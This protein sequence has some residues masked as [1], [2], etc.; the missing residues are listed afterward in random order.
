MADWSARPEQL[1]INLILIPVHANAPP[2]GEREEVMIIDIAEPPETGIV[3]VGDLTV[4]FGRR[5][6]IIGGTAAELTNREFEL[7]SYL[8]RNLNQAISRDQLF[9]TVWGYNLDF[10][11]NS[12]DVY[13]YRIRRR[14]E[15]NPN[16]PQYLKTMRGFGYKMV[17]PS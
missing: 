15:T 7:V 9:E 14:I 6:V 10:N 13:I 11:S 17:A 12:L 4:D 1:F 2:F 5:D 3:Q 16:R 8:T